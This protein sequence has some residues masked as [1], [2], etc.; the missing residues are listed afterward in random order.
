LY[1]EGGIRCLGGYFR[2]AKTTS[3]FLLRSSKKPAMAISLPSRGVEGE[4]APLFVVRSLSRKLKLVQYG[5]REGEA[6]SKRWQLL[7]ELTA[8]FSL[9]KQGLTKVFEKL[10]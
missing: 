8:T 3:P 10:K 1:Q 5:F 4:R 2:K 6:F 7:F 9:G